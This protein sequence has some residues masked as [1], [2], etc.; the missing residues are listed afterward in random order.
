MRETVNDFE[1]PP[2]PWPIRAFNALGPTL[3]RGGLLPQLED[4]LEADADADLVSGYVI[5]R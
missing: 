3:E 1:R 2:P 4:V 5:D